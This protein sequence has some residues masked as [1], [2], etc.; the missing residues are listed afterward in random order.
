MILKIGLYLLTCYYRPVKR[1]KNWLHIGHQRLVGSKQWRS[2]MLSKTELK[3]SESQQQLKL[4]RSK[5]DRP[6]L[7]NEREEARSK[8]LLT[9]LCSLKH[10]SKIKAT[11]IVE[12]ESYWPFL[13]HHCSKQKSVKLSGRAPAY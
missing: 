1:L 10:R 11:H 3:K 12:V 13:K 6:T 4:K 2:S 9:A 5:N 8:L 7:P